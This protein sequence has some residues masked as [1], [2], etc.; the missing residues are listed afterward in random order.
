M[1]D[2]N[3]TI[4]GSTTGNFDQLNGNNNSVANIQV[5]ETATITR[6]DGSGIHG[7]TTITLSVAANSTFTIT[8]YAKLPYNNTDN[9][10]YSTTIA[11]G[12][13]SSFSV[14]TLYLG[15]RNNA[16]TTGV[17]QNSTINFG[18]N[19]TLTA[20]TIQSVAEIKECS[21]SL[22]LAALFDTQTMSSLSDLSLAGTTYSRTLIT[23]TNGF[24]DLS[25]DDIS[26]SAITSLDTLGYEK[27][28][29]ITSLDKLEA[30]QYGLLYANKKVS[31]VAKTIPEPTTATLSL[32]ALAGL[33]ARR[34]RR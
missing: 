11:L 24:V 26:L 23:M 18:S 27:V 17:I 3:L 34:R 25:T 6:I 7:L 10:T 31:L 14:G 20:G 1:G 9:K 29:V 15:T 12:D 30:G 22:T 28:G 2:Q 4:N 16:N 5:T 21:S 33:A 13:N 32:L 19:A 8:G